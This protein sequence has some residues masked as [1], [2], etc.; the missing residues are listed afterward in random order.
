MNEDLDSVVTQCPYATNETMPYGAKSGRRRREK[1][2]RHGSPPKNDADGNEISQ[3]G[4]KENKASHSPQKKGRES[5]NNDD[6]RVREHKDKKEASKKSSSGQSAKKRKKPDVGQEEVEISD[7]KY[8]SSYSA[9]SKSTPR[10]KTVRKA[11]TPMVESLTATSSSAIASGTLQWAG[12][13]SNDGTVENREHLSL[14]LRPVVGSAVSVAFEGGIFDGKVFEAGFYDGKIAAVSEGV[15]PGTFK[16]GVTFEDG[17]YEEC[18]YPAADV[19]LKT[20][21]EG[22]R[23][24]GKSIMPHE[25]GT[26]LFCSNHTKLITT[27]DISIFLFLVYELSRFR[28]AAV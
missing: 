12:Q 20:A 3:S 26:S 9:E 5:R 8:S 25:Y 22:G 21:S 27:F 11:I 24:P 23:N 1:V 18:N 10:E 16:I 28:S 15:V 17:S 6:G 2:A 7:N 13:P 19:K 4:G 14:P